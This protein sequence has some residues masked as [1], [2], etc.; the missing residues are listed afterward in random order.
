[1]EFPVIE[2]HDRGFRVR[3]NQ[4]VYLPG[5]YLKYIMAQKALARYVAQQLDYNKRRRTKKEQ[6]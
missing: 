1:M 3:L 5:I 2:N 4:N 6:D